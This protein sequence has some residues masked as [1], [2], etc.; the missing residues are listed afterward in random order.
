MDGEFE[1]LLG[2]YIT[3]LA[4]AKKVE[5][6]FSDNLVIISGETGAGKS[7]LM[8]SI[9]IV[10]GA[11]ATSDVI[12]N[13]AE[14]ASIE[15]SFSLG[16]SSRTKDILEKFSLYDGD[17]IVVISRNIS[18]NRTRS[19]VNGHPIS[20]KELSLIGRSL[21]DMHGQHE[22]QSLLNTDTHLR[23]VDAFGGEE[24]LELRSKVI[25]EISR[26][27]EIKHKKQELEEADRKYIEERDFINFE[28]AEL[29]E[30][31]LKPDEEEELESEEKVLSNS[32]ELA[33]LLQTVMNIL[34]YSEENSVARELSIVSNLMG[35]ASSITETLSPLREEIENIE[36]E[37]KEVARDLSALSSNFVF[38]PE[39]LEAIQERLTFLSTLKL[40]YRREIPELIQY[41]SD[42]KEKV[43]GF[44]SLRDEIDKLEE[45]E[46]DLV[47]HIRED[48]ARLSEMRKNVAKELEVSVEAQLRDLAMENAMFEVSFRLFDDPDGVEIGGK[49]V[50]L[51]AD[52]IDSAE[53]LI[54]P[55]PGEDFKPLAS[56]ASGG[57]LSRIML[58]IKY[59]VASV[60][61]IPVLA[62][63]EVDAGIGGKTGER[64]AEKLLEISK[65]RQVICIT[66]LPQIASLPGE[67]FVVEKVVENDETFLNVKK[68]ED[69]ERVGEIARMISGTNVTETTIKQSKELLSRWK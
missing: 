10:C 64:V 15:A 19:L 67:H 20:V 8:N 45:E 59:V 21:V 57:E 65:Y 36:I 16:N 33:E 34:S 35:K 25:E 13:G 38:D 52:G 26:F 31:N 42:L 14:S 27:K 18:K 58:S 22:V 23:F 54:K 66:H 50:K 3:N 44:N 5:L 37:L 17:D 69:Y 61:E 28:I 40:K 48:A 30:A 9:G 62:F 60:D 39:R 24:I 2:L 29:T 53:F 51:L 41:L 43:T 4:I 6:N 47:E 32:K 63:D 49:R 7:I 1:V 12:R 11:G 68:I 56:I 46:A 55:N